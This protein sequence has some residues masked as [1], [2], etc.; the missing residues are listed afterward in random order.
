MKS[1]LLYIIG[2]LLCHSAS[3]QS[4]G[5]LEH[6]YY[7]TRQEVPAIVPIVHYNT[8]SNWYGEA[9]YNYEDFNTLSLYGGKTFS[10]EGRWSWSATPLVG[11]M[12][13]TMNGGSLGFNVDLDHKNVFFSSQSQYSF[14]L[15]D[16]LNK[17]FFTWSEIGYQPLPWCYAGMALQQTSA[18]QQTGLWETGYMIGFSFGKWT[19]PLYA[20]GVS[21]RDKYFILGVNWEWLNNKQKR[22]QTIVYE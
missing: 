2:F 17:Y 21:K 8:S 22:T 9:R 20:F 13:G 5:G 7:V 4:G 16:R 14:S 1:K 6:Y 12:V 18:Y 10:K 3:G 15:E 11:G 19:I